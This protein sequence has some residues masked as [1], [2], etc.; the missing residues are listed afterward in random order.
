MDSEATFRSSLSIKSSLGPLDQW[1]R[2]C[3]LLLHPPRHLFAV[4]SWP[5]TAPE[6]HHC[7]TLR[8]GGK[9]DISRPCHLVLGSASLRKGGLPPIL[10]FWLTDHIQN[11]MRRW[12]PP[13]DRPSQ[14]PRLSMPHQSLQEAIHGWWDRSWEVGLLG[15]PQAR[16]KASFL[17]EHSTEGRFFSSGPCLC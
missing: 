9:S 6:L 15:D 10:V 1:P 13:A 8:K 3:L 2:F 7:S 14:G 17:H 12:P 16:P 11:S 5:S 4:W